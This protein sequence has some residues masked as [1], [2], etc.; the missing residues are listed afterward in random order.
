MTV[1]TKNKKSRKEKE[2]VKIIFFAI[3]LRLGAFA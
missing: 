2:Y 3:T 1:I